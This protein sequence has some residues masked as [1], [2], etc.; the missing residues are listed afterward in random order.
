VFIQG[1]FTDFAAELSG[2]PFIQNVPFVER[3]R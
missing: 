1:L 3:E 2:V